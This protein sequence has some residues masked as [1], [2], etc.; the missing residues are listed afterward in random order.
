MYNVYFIHR[1]NPPVGLVLVV[2]IPTFQILNFAR[3]HIDRTKI[4]TF[5]F[6]GKANFVQKNEHA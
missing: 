5:N 1:H 2:Q 4:E 6:L 3:E